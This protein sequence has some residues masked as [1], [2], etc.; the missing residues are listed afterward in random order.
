MSGVTSQ[1]TGMLALSDLRD[2]LESFDREVRIFAETILNQEGY[3]NILIAFNI[4][5][6]NRGIRPDETEIEKEPKGREKSTKY[7]RYTTYLKNKLGQ[8]TDVVTLRGKTG[9]FQG[10]IDVKVGY[11]TIYFIDRDIKASLLEAVWGQVLGITEDQLFEFVEMIT[12]EFEKF[13]LKRFAL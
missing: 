3:K 11:D 4:E 6:L 9:N 1:M 12:P 7:E 5:N 2:K 10:A 8:P 13:C